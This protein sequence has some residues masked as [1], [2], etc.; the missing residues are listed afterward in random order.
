MIQSHSVIQAGVQW[1]DLSSRQPLPPGFKQF[2]CLSLLSSWY[3]RHTPLRPANFCIFSKDC[4]SPSWP[5]WSWTPLFITSPQKIQLKSFLFSYLSKQCFFLLKSVYWDFQHFL[6]SVP[7]KKAI[8][9]SCFAILPYPVSLRIIE[10]I[11]SNTIR[12]YIK[13]NWKFEDKWEKL[14]IHVDSHLSS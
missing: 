7:F 2:S 5:D 9:L 10:I 12:I 1:C 8:S 3:H 6:H 14:L 4:A 11:L 13:K